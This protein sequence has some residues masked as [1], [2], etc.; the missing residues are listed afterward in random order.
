MCASICEFTCVTDI[1]ECERNP[2]LCRGGS[3]ENTEGSYQCVCPPGHQVSE[4]GDAC[5]GAN[6]HFVQKI[7]KPVI[8]LNK[9]M[10][11]NSMVLEYVMP[12]NLI[13]K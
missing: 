9:P 1:D 7:Q 6:T 5:E 3:C 13:P 8:Y 10:N 4:D 11:C 12:F 2:A